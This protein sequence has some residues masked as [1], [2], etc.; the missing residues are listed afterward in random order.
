MGKY[1]PSVFSLRVGR[2]E[3]YLLSLSLDHNSLS[4]NTNLL[5]LRC[6]DI[7]QNPGPTKWP[8][9]KCRKSA[10]TRSVQCNNCKEWIH[11]ACSSLSGYRSYST[12]FTCGY[13][14]STSASNTTPAVPLQMNVNPPTKSLAKTARTTAK[15]KTPPKPKHRQL[16]PDNLPVQHPDQVS[17]YSNGTYFN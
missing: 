8:C 10:A 6:G 15:T 14:P 2:F 13:C 7:A 9:P 1:S 16:P 11:L 12:S 4:L 3:H 17:P 5:L